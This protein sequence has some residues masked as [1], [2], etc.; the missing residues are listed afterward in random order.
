[1]AS[2]GA[3]RDSISRALPLILSRQLPVGWLAGADYFLL[4]RARR[5]A[6]GLLNSAP[7]C[8]AA[9]PA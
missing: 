3:E 4:A 8:Q 6:A 7:G 9:R 5:A 1:M 2:S